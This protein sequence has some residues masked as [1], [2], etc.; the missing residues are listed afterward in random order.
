MINETTQ[1]AI[2][3]ELNPQYLFSLT[4]TDLL[5]QIANG[6]IDAKKIATMQLGI[7]GLNLEGKWVGF[8]SHN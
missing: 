3:D 5:V 2:S 6:S 8:K 4:A 1:T 7:R